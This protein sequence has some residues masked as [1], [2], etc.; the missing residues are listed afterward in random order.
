MAEDIPKRSKTKYVWVATLN[1]IGLRDLKR[2]AQRKESA[3]TGQFDK[4]AAT[5]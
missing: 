3:E 1:R 5:S 2:I 4:L